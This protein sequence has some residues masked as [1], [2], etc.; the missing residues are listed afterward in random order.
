MNELACI[1]TTTQAVSYLDTRF[2]RQLSHSEQEK[3]PPNTAVAGDSSAKAAFCALLMLEDQRAF[4]LKLINDRRYW[5]RLRSLVGS[6]PYVFLRPGDDG[7]LNASGIHRQ[8][9][10]IASSETRM[11]SASDFGFGHFR[12]AQQRLYRVV[13][14]KRLSGSV[15]WLGL[16]SGERVVVDVKLKHSTRDIKDAVLRGRTEHREQL[17][18]PRPGDLLSLTLVRQLNPGDGDV[19]VHAVVECGRQKAQL[20][21]IAR[22]VLK[23]GG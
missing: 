11:S 14:K 16:G 21:S 19:I 1:S 10:H 7:L 4:F 23:I 5:P 8:R 3:A 13:A 18:F 12:H 9:M 22:L 15:P 2:K 20:A 6:P 17:V